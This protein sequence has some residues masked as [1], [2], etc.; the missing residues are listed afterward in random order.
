MF[1]QQKWLGRLDQHPHLVAIP[2]KWESKLTQQLGYHGE[3][4]CVMFSVLPNGRGLTWYD[5]VFGAMGNMHVW[6]QWQSDRVIRV[7][8]RGIDL[9]LQPNGEGYALLFD[10]VQSMVHVGRHQQMRDLLLALAKEQELSD[11]VEQLF[12]HL[13]ID[14]EAPQ[15]IDARQLMELSQA[16][17]RGARRDPRKLH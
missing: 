17:D 13:G 10:H 5:G 15:D 16:I 11:G 12:A 1:E 7:A 2:L 14:A 8:L 3:S 6:Q 9:S 4:A